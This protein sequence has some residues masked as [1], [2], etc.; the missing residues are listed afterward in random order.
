MRV[1]MNVWPISHLVSSKLYHAKVCL[2]VVPANIIFLAARLAK[3]L[4]DVMMNFPVMW[5]RKLLKLIIILT[6]VIVRVLFI[7][8]LV[9]CVVTMCGVCNGLDASLRDDV[10]LL[11][12]SQW[13]FWKSQVILFLSSEFDCFLC[14]CLSDILFSFYLILIFQGHL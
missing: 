12:F 4:K 10:K 14:Y 1:N 13:F 9:R 6:V 11:S 2:Y 3:M 7:W 5:L 8:Y